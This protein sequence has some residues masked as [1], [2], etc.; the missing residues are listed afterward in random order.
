MLTTLLYFPGESQTLRLKVSSHFSFLV[1][2]AIGLDT[3]QFERSFF[4]LIYFLEQFQA[5]NKSRRLRDLCALCL[6]IAHL[7]PPACFLGV[8]VC[9]RIEV[10]IQVLPKGLTQNS[11]LF[12]T[13]SLICKEDFVIFFVSFN[14]DGL[15]HSGW[16]FL[17]L[18]ICLH[19]S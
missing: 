13:L 3:T 12:W 9:W 10:N 15:L 11:C 1:A 7:T 14:H 2:G 18:F 6:R 5:D 19:F 16:S 4:F 8:Q 17:V